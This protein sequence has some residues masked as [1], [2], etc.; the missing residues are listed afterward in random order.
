MTGGTNL[1]RMT[2]AEVKAI[3]DA[4]G[5]TKAMAEQLDITE[6]AVRF[7]LQNGAIRKSTINRLKALAGS[8]RGRG[9]S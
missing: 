5:G 2:P 8:K 6:R 1:P 3:R 9:V 4:V 7:L